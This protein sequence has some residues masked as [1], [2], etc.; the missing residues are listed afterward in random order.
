MQIIMVFSYAHFQGPCLAAAPLTG[1][2][3]ARL[4]PM[5]IVI[6]PVASERP[7]VFQWRF[8][9][10]PGLPVPGSAPEV[11]RPETEAFFT[12]LTEAS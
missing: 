5:I 2:E 8:E 9:K 1:C 3:E 11:S 6:T 12:W 10:R 4:I 7:P